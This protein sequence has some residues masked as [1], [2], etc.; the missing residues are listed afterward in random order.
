MS[1]EKQIINEM[2]LAICKSRG[3][4]EVDDCSK[5]GRYA[6]CL[7]YE[8]ACGLYKADYRRQSEGEWIARHHMSRSPRGRYTSYNTYICGVCGKANGRRKSPF[9]PHC[10]AK[11]KGGAEQR[12]V[13][14]DTNV[15]HKKYFTPEDV[16]KMTRE[17]VKANYTAILDSMKKWQ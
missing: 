10:G 17:E 16:R 12:E 5:C 11:M 6:D 14:T 9:C 15:S 4:A 2:A 7:Y 13:V 8:I 3:V 1:K